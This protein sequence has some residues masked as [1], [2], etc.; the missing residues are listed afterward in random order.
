MLYSMT[1]YGAARRETEELSVS[2]EAKSVNGRFLKVVL[3]LPP[4]L[5]PLEN[6]IENL[7]RR[8]LQRGS[9]S[10]AVELRLSDASVYVSINEDI[11]RAYQQEFRR[12][13]LNEDRI[14]L[15]PGVM[16]HSETKV[17]EA[18]WTT[19]AASV[20][21]ALDDMRRMRQRE[22]QALAEAI[23]GMLDQVEHWVGETARRAP[24]VVVEYH[25]K[26]HERVRAL[27]ERL[28][29]DLQVA[30]DRDQVAR[31]VALYADRCDITE[32][33]DRLRAHVAQTRDLLKKGGAVGRTLEFLAQEMHR[34]VNTVG[35]KSA[36]KEISRLVVALKSELERIKEQVANVE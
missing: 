14:S 26:L 7:I 5:S 3:K 23:S 20:E 18:Q 8:K 17:T 33:L 6:E 31:E 30:I 35:S 22:G 24:A 21:Q 27:I 1:G 15:L 32:E 16:A 25:D 4:A 12:L 11:V 28:G 13:G 2:V 34:E 19:I 36:D 29:N 9:V 10:L